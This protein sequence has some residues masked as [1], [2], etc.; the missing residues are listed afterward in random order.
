[1]HYLP[2]PVPYALADIETE[3]DDQQKI[4]TNLANANPDRL[5]VH[6]IK[7]DNNL[8]QREVDVFIAHQNQSMEKS[9]GYSQQTG[10]LMQIERGRAARPHPR[11]LVGNHQAER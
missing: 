3:G 6:T 8:R 9:E 1:M 10:V 5:I 11:Q 7:R 2:G 4:K